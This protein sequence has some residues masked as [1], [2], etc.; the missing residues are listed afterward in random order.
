MGEYI[1]TYGTFIGEKAED[2]GLDKGKNLTD[3][4][5]VS[6]TVDTLIGTLAKNNVIIDQVL[7]QSHDIIS[8]QGM[9]LRIEE[10]TSDNEDDDK[11]YNSNETELKSVSNNLCKNNKSVCREELSTYGGMRMLALIPQIFTFHIL[12]VIIFAILLIV[13]GSMW[14]ILEIIE[15]FQVMMLSDE[16]KDKRYQEK[17]KEVDIDEKDKYTWVSI[18]KYIVE[19]I[20]WANCGLGPSNMFKTV[21]GIYTVGIFIWGLTHLGI[22]LNNSRIDAPPPIV[23]SEFAPNQANPTT[24]PGILY[25]IRFPIISKDFFSWIKD[26]WIVTPMAARDDGKICTNGFEPTSDGDV[27]KREKVE[28]DY[29]KENLDWCITGGTCPF[30]GTLVEDKEKYDEYNKKE[31]IK[32]VDVGE[33]TAP[34]EN[35]C[36]PMKGIG[37]DFIEDATK[38]ADDTGKKIGSIFQ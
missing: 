24:P 3:E 4:V 7:R 29:A 14:K 9:G 21:I 20:F 25:F 6:K 33:I 35:R 16:E 26:P 37:E 12:I 15:F 19:T 11:Y 2:Y 31:K 36:Q 27:Q 32:Y 34:F 17:K 10:N 30:G 1:N 28:Y 18:F 38:F 23:V 13:V 5:W 8:H 22:W